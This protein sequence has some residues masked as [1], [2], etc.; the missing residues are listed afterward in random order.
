MKA[1]ETEGDRSE[2]VRQAKRG[3]AMARSLP[4]RRWQGTLTQIISLTLTRGF[5]T[6]LIC[7]ISGR[8]KTEIM[9]RFGNVR[10]KISDPI[11]GMLFCF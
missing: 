5:L 10:F 3:V 2:E 9:S 6:D 8:I 1:L 4:F 11:W 7:S